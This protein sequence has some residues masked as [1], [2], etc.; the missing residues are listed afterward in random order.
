MTSDLVE[1]YGSPELAVAGRW[2][3]CSSNE[4]GTGSIRDAFAELF[5][6]TSVIQIRLRYA[7]F[8]PWLYTE[9]ESDRT[10]TSANVERRA[11]DLLRSVG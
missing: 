11:D 8:I 1:F 5:P 6:G 7:L 2:R 9:L 4:L 3:A 10:V